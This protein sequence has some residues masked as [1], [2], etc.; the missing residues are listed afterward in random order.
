M[1]VSR[2]VGA[3]IQRREDPRLVSGRGRYVDDLS[4]PAMLHMAIVRSPHA[5]ARVNRIDTSPALA[6]PGGVAAQG[7]AEAEVVVKERIRQ[8]RVF[9]LAMEGRAVVASYDPFEDRLQV[10]ISC[11]APHFIRRW[12]AAGLQ[13]PEARIR[14]ISNDVGGG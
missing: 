9:P 7:F 8:Q 14:V 12:L 10:W 6:L 4:L 5:H 3:R 13:M 1:A 11:Q 2:L